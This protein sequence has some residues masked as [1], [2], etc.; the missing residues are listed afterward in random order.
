M[1]A[2]KLFLLIAVLSFQLFAQSAGTILNKIQQKYNSYENISA[3][4]K[5][6]NLKQTAPALKGK[7]FYSKGKVKLLLPAAQIVIIKDTVWNYNKKLNQLAISLNEEEKPLFDFGNFSKDLL[8]NFNASVRK[9]KNFFEI[10]LTPKGNNFEFEKLKLIVGKN[11]LIRSVQAKG[12]SFNRVKIDF[13]N[14]G[15]NKITKRN[16][17]KIKVPKNC[18]IIDLR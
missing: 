4:F 9:R 17:F 2:V 18:R 11:F 10:I 3:E 1:K 14:F 7:I 6:F 16:F 8:R 5:Q 15:F 13:E 12:E